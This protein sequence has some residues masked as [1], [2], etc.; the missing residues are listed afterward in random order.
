MT[1]PSHWYEAGTIAD[2]R[3]KG[4]LLFRHGPLQLAIFQVDEQIFAIDNR[5]PHEGY[6]LVEGKI[7][8]GEKVLTCNWHNW[9]FDLHSGRCLRGSDN[10]R[11][12]PTKSESGSIW[13]EIAPPNKEEI[14]TRLLAGLKQAIAKQEYG[15]IARTLA[16]L[17]F[18]GIDL[19]R[20]LI[21]AIE[22]SYDRLEF[23]TTHAYA[24]TADW[25]Q[26]YQESPTNLESQII[27]LAEAIDHIAQDSL[28]HPSYPY[29]QTSREFSHAG[30]LDA[31]EKE[32]EE[33]ALSQLRGAFNAGK[34]FAD[35]EHSLTAAALAHYNDFGHSLIYVYKSRYLIEQL[36]SCVEQPLSL[37]LGRSLCGATREDLLP[38][39]RKYTHYLDA[40]SKQPPSSQQDVEDVEDLFGL[41]VNRAM[42]W[43][44]DKLQSHAPMAVFAALLEVNARNLLC[45]D[46]G[47]QTASDRSVSDNV[48]WLDFTHAITFANAARMQCSRFPEFWPQALLQL[49]CFHGRNQPY[50]TAVDEERWQVE[51]SERFFAAASEQIFDHGMARPIYSAH[52]LKTT[53]AVREELPTATPSG[54]R[55]LLAALNR[56]LH[57]PIKTKH[58]RRVAKQAISLVSRDFHS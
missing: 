21:H 56:F 5:C 22:N 54:T 42:Q 15:R 27:A 1:N 11:V 51:N 10:T 40:A 25:L 29:P 12:Y 55:Y 57:S 53:I 7:A 35:L 18:N 44:V 38:E 3:K 48:G 24:A 33:G 37:A 50:T 26:L 43:V 9:K 28:R 23:G 58:T 19:K 8:A 13:V 39:F 34:S 16:R 49:A 41:S 30:F 32:D 14:A 6:P 4:R 17:H 36:G 20:A 46:M 52:L 2:L 47:F 45:Y 31:V